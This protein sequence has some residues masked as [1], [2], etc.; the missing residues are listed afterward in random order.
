MPEHHDAANAARSNYEVSSMTVTI[1]DGLSPDKSDTLNPF[2]VG[3]V[4][5]DE[6]GDVF[7]VSYDLYREKKE[8]LRVGGDYTL[9]RNCTVTWPIK[10]SSKAV[11][12]SN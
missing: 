9:Y 3:E 4:I 12:F 2:E 1:T 11:T 5:E 10:L 7:L 8:L 6:D